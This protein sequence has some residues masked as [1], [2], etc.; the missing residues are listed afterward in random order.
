[1]QDLQDS[2]IR[3]FCLSITLGVIYRGPMLC[4]PKIFTKL[5]KIFVFKLTSI[6]SNDGGRYTIPADDVIRYEQ[7]YGLAS[8][9]RERY[10]L[11]P[12]CEVIRSCDDELVSIR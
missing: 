8:S 9:V 12:F 4:N 7:S 6:I 1:M 2:F 10:C 3:S 5:F 11:Y